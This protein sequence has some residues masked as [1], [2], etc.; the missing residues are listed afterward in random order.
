VH[1]LYLAAQY[2]LHENSIFFLLFNI[3]QLT[4]LAQCDRYVI[5]EEDKFEKSTSYKGSFVI[6][7]ETFQA[8]FL[9]TNSSKSSYINFNLWEFK[10]I[11]GTSNRISIHPGA[12]IHFLFK[13]GTDYKVHNAPENETINETFFATG[14]WKNGFDELSKKRLELW[15]KL[16]TDKLD[17]IRVYTGT[18]KYDCTLTEAKSEYILNTFKCMGF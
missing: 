4:L 16:K 13:D 3:S 9:M 5:Q 8:N 14:F 6:S 12:Y 7:S 11:T 18:E 2:V 17:A 10:G 15:N 1:L